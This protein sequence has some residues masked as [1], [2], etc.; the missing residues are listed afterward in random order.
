MELTRQ[1]LRSIFDQSN[2]RR[3][4]GLVLKASDSTYTAMPHRWVKLKVSRG[5]ATTPLTLQKD[6]IPGLGD[7]I[8]LVVV[9]AGWDVDRARELHGG[10]A[11]HRC[12]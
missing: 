9:G 1:A 6:Y 2:A 5:S 10:S 8:D 11:L 3:E 7:C 4:E 12:H